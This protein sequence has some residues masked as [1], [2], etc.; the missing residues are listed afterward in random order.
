[1]VCPRTSRELADI[2]ASI[3]REIT[4]P[5]TRPQWWQAKTCAT[6]QQRRVTESR[7]AWYGG[8]RS[9]IAERV[10]ASPSACAPREGIDELKNI[11]FARRGPENLG[12]MNK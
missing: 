3:R 4:L 7:G 1:M 6:S 11:C 12:E 5:T 10:G 8:G 9:E 2:R